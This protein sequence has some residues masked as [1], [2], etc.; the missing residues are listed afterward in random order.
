MAAG[1]NGAVSFAGTLLGALA[2]GLVALEAIVTGLLK[3]RF[4][5]VIVIAGI[6]GMLLDSLLGATLERRGWLTNNLVNLIS[7]GASATMAAVVAW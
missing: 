7:T 2:A 6:V 3:A 4:G 1:T 5:V